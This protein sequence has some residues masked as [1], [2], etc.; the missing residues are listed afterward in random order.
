M[1]SGIGIGKVD[2][3]SDEQMEREYAHGPSAA[4]HE[5][6]KNESMLIS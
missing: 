3:I 6:H 1:R 5:L 4:G 2:I